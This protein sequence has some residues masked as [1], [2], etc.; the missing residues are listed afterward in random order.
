MK[1]DKTRL[2]GAVAAIA[3][4]AAAGGF[5]L[6]ALINRDAPPAVEA[7]DEHAEGESHGE[8]EAAEASEGVVKLTPEQVRASGLAVVAVGRGG[9]AETRISGRVEPMVD[10][11][12]SVGAS[13]GGRVERVLVA[14]GQSIRAGQ[15]LAVLVSGDA[16]T[17]RA[18]A[19]AAAAAANA[20]R[21]AYERDRN[22][23]T[24]GIVAR[25]EVESSQAQAL[26][27]EA[28][29]R[30]AR[31]R[32]AVAGSPNAS[33]RTSVSSPI[34]GVVTAVQV[35]PGGYVT[36]G[37][38]IAE[39]TNPAR[40]ELVFNAPPQLAAQTRAG[41][42]MRITAQTGEF[43]AVVTGVAANAGSGESGATVIRARPE[44]ASLPPA[45]SPVTGALVTGGES[46]GLTVPSEAVQTVEGNS[47]VFV[48][49][50]GGFRAAQVL[51]GRQAGGRTEIVR[52]LTGAER[53]VSTNAFLLKAELAKGEAEHGH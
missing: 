11:R 26:S 32:V 45:G 3:L 30:A 34:G 37:G 43:D 31:A 22:L 24:Q 47:V 41:A 44:G 42:R 38:V 53:I 35:G 33:G 52:G 28:T 25:Q 15:A 4:V 23:G 18:D 10:A 16:A 20:A 27:A 36:Q 12:A 14:P 5:G 21:R 46:G 51:T 1:Q 2:Y 48:Q 49:V 7:A 39:V 17:L 6:S 50:E 29:A 40:V 13:V 19:D 8:G 9:G